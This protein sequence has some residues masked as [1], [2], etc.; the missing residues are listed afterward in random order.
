[1]EKYELEA[2]FLLTAILVALYFFPK[3]ERLESLVAWIARTPSLTA[4]GITLLLSACTLVVYMNHPLSM[5]EYVDW[6]QTCL[7]GCLPTLHVL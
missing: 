7:S 5:D 3:V 4:I 1:M 2:A 6:F